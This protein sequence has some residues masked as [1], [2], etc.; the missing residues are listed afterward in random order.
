M[1]SWQ[2]ALK[3]LPLL[4]CLV[5]VLVMTS[6]GIVATPKEKA[7]ALLLS[8]IELRQQQIAEPTADRLEQMK[9][10]GIRVADLEIQRIFIHLTN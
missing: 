6:C 2:A 9:A 5:L 4:I 8:Q 10:M 1:D 7:S 3:L